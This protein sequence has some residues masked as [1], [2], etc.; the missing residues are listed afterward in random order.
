MKDY[1]DV[2]LMV[3]SFVFIVGIISGVALYAFCQQVLLK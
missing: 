3:L 2:A 1:D